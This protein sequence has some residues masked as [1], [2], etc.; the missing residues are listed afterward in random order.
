M[1]LWTLS[2]YEYNRD[3]RLVAGT[4][5]ISLAVEHGRIS[6]CR[7]YGDFFGQGDISDVENQLQGVRV[8]KGDIIA[9]LNELDVTYYFGKT[10]AEELAD[11]ILS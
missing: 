1:E 7:I 6:A 9:A 10:S 2:R 11:V 5:D 8:V 3:A 4:I